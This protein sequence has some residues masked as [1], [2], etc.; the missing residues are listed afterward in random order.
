MCVSVCVCARQIVKTAWKYKQTFN[1][2]SCVVRWL[3][4]QISH[5]HS[6]SNNNNKFPKYQND[7]LFYWIFS[8]YTEFIQCDVLCSS[9]SHTHRLNHILKQKSW[10]EVGCESHWIGANFYVCANVNRL[11]WFFSFFWIYII[12]CEYTETVDATNNI[13]YLLTPYKFVVGR[14][15]MMFVWCLM[16][17]K[18]NIAFQEF[19][20]FHPY[21]AL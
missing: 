6:S 21:S 13:I 15:P 20:R 1:V 7:R 14:I 3:P 16:F 5:T 18:L 17:D 12:F 4:L 11:H 2:Y 10:L 9:I 8:I 19:R